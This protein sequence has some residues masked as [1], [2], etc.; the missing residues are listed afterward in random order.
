MAKN[1]EK[2]VGS[3]QI[4]KEAIK[5]SSAHFTLFPNA[6]AERLHGHNYAVKLTCTGPL[7]DYDMVIDMGIVKTILKDICNA[8][9]E[10]ILLP[11][12]SQELIIENIS[13]QV[14]LSWKDRRYA[15]PSADVVLLP[16]ANITIEGLGVIDGRGT[17]ETFPRYS[18]SGRS[19][20]GLPRP[21][22]VRMDN[23]D[24]L[25][26]S[27][28][29]Y[30]RPAFWGLHLID[31]RNIHFNAV[32]IR[33]RNNNFNNDGIVGG[34]DFVIL[35]IDE[36]QVVFAQL[37]QMAQVFIADCVPLVEGRA[38]ELTGTNLGNIMGQFRSHGLLK[39][40]FF[41]H[42]FFSLI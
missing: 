25:T 16:L 17:H 33:F 29:T 12:N 15:F 9:D 27:G 23:C 34:P 42:S 41:E 6:E 36:I 11:T 26:F 21:R 30:K 24:K 37:L 40:Y 18:G 1:E 39:F 2:P 5:F 38:L 7:D 3:L 31:C 8:W 13:G 14:N 10:K 22:L 4:G 35:Q 19:R 28:V 32:T 20:R